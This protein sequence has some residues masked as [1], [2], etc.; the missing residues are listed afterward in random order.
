L[1]NLVKILRLV[2]SGIENAQTFIPLLM[3]YETTP[4]RKSSDKPHGYLGGKSPASIASISD[5]VV[6]LSAGVIPAPRDQAIYQAECAHSVDQRPDKA[7]Q[8]R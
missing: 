2:T 1:L 7:I 4:M 3:Q 5:E 8:A 6:I